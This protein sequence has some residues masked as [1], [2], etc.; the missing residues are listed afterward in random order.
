MDHPAWA[1]HIRTSGSRVRSTT[2]A[3]PAR[4]SVQA[5]T[6]VATKCD[7]GSGVAP[8][9]YALRVACRWPGLA[10]H[11]L[12][13]VPPCRCAQVVYGQDYLAPE[14][15]DRLAALR[16]EVLGHLAGGRDTLLVVEEYD[17]LDCAARGMWRQL[18]AHPERANLTGHRRARQH[19]PALVLLLLLLVVLVVVAVV[20]GALDRA[21]SHTCHACT[22]P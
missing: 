12:L 19:Q 3:P 15:G 11:P 17:K 4:Y 14:A 22:G 13:A 8:R 1:R 6:V 20:A 5:C 16:R 9:L 2:D 7:G 21:C 10:T 18:L